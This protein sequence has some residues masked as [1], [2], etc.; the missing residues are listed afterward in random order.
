MYN[1]LWLATGIAAD[2]RMRRDDHNQFHEAVVATK[3]GDS[4]SRVLYGGSCP[5]RNRRSSTT[6][7]CCAC[8]NTFRMWYCAVG[9]TNKGSNMC[10]TD[11]RRG[12]RQCD[13]HVEWIREAKR[14]CCCTER[15]EC[16]ICGCSHV[17][18]I[19]S[20]WPRGGHNIRLFTHSLCV[21]WRRIRRKRISMV[22]VDYVGFIPSTHER[23][24]AP[25]RFEPSA[26]QVVR[27]CRSSRSICCRCSH[28]CGIDIRCDV[29]TIKPKH[30]QRVVQHR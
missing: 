1:R 20:P 21:C 29:Q 2:W 3:C 28:R 17:L 26:C 5:A 14:G 6:F 12:M 11:G 23:Q 4:G 8:R 30:P 9:Y 15:R 10:C 19:G 7:R 24:C 25:G 22:D 27:S 18:S 16:D 13:V